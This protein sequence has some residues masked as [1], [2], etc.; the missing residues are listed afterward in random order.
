[1]SYQAKLIAAIFDAASR[2]HEHP[3][4]QVYHN[5]F[6][7]NGIRAL[8][9]SF[10]TLAYFMDEAN[11]RA[12]A[13]AF[14]LAH[15][16]HQFDW[17]D[18]GQALPSFLM[19]YPDR[20]EYPYLVEVAEMDWLLQEVQRCADKRFDGE[21]FS[22][23]EKESLESLQFDTAPGFTIASFFFPVDML[24][25]LANDAALANPGARR[26]AFVHKLNKSMS[27]AIN[28]DNPRSMLLWRPDY[29]PE[30]LSLTD[31]ETTPMTAL[32]NRQS[33]ADV[34]SHL[35]DK[36]AHISDWLNKQI[37]SKRIYGVLSLP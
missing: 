1:M 15:P 4:V 34:F 11:F 14:L 12:L 7:E 23:L 9:I 10:P 25:Q 28:S 33:I 32:K 30:V 5:N 36:P 18:Y 31:H 24:Y 16:K 26:D 21:S 29:K 35:A 3:G 20:L 13:R 8:S 22:L 27:L 19:S 2:Q 6:I 17:A 37:A